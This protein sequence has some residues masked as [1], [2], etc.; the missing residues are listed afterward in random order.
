MGQGEGDLERVRSSPAAIRAQMTLVF[1]GCP[2]ANR[3]S[4]S[5]A[6]YDVR[7]A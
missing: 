2:R 5:P 6:H 4:P 7:E 1:A 3:P